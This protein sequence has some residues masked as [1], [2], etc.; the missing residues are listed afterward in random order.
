MIRIF[1][2]SNDLDALF[3]AFDDTGPDNDEKEEHNVEQL[4]VATTD[5]LTHKNE[6]NDKVDCEPSS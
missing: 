5:S 1:L 3:G 6:P 2:M 4:L